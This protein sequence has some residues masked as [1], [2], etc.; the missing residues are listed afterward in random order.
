MLLRG[1]S[2]T[3]QLQHSM[4]PC[5][6]KLHCL[7]LQLLCFPQERM[8]A[9][10]YD[11]PSPD[12]DSESLPLNLPSLRT[13]PHPGPGLRSGCASNTSSDLQHRVLGQSSKSI[14]V[15][16]HESYCLDPTS[17]ACGCG[18]SGTILPWRGVEITSL[19]SCSNS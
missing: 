7:S 13:Q 3:T 15:K 2:M 4:A 17:M 8:N 10:W 1:L 16:M 11:P 9:R 14:S 18:P 12:S 19:V 5:E 6:T